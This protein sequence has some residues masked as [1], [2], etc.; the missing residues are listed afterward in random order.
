MALFRKTGGG[1]AAQGDIMIA[2]VQRA[3]FYLTGGSG[4]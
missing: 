4:Q 2:A 3:F 1:S